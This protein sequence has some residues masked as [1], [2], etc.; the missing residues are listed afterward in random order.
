MLLCEDNAINQEIAR[1]ILEEKGLIVT[2]AKDG[3][4]GTRIFERSSHGYYSVI[5][6][7]IR[8]PVMDGFAATK[9]IRSLARSDAQSIPIIAMSANAFS[10]DIQKCLNAGMNGHLAKPIEPEKLFETLLSFVA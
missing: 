10:E 3:L 4:D 1:R 7:D 2:I 9:A 6:M 5:L 8:M